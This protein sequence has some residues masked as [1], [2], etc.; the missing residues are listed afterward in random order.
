MKKLAILASAIALL[1][2]TGCAGP[3]GTGYYYDGY[4]YKTYVNEPVR[5]CHHY[6][7]CHKRHKHCHKHHRHCHKHH[8]HKHKR[9]AN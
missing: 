1:G 5:H 2:L 9:C 4:Y 8:H 3:N 6:K 7:H